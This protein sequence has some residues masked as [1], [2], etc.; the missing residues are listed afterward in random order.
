[1]P[2]DVAFIYAGGDGCRAVLS[3]SA[4]IVQ[5][6]AAASRSPSGLRCAVGYT[7]LDPAATY[8]GWTPTRK[9]GGGAVL[10]IG[11]YATARARPRAP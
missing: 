10:A 4:S 3:S 7:N 9:I 6:A 1:M 2:G 11:V 8:K 5:L